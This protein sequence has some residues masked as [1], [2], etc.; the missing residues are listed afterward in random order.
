MWSSKIDLHAH[1]YHLRNFNQGYINFS[2]C[3]ELFDLISILFGPYYLSRW[4]CAIEIDDFLTRLLSLFLTP[5]LPKP[6]TSVVI[7]DVTATSVKLTWNAGNVE[8]IESY[9]IQYNRKFTPGASYEEIADIT[10]TE[11]T[12]MGLDAYM[13]YEF[14]V[15]AVNNIGRGIPSNPVDVTTGELG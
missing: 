6:P 2:I 1:R 7:S 11:Y 4:F 9:I 8:P 5:A 15:V 14:R 10:N 12:V 13:V 3:L